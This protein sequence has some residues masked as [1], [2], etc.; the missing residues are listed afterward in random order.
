MLPKELKK[1][2]KQQ[3][4]SE[5]KFIEKNCVLHLNFFPAQGAT[6]KLVVPSVFLPKA[7]A[8]KIALASDDPKEC[9]NQ[10]REIVSEVAETCYENANAGIDKFDATGLI[11]L[12]EELSKFVYQSPADGEKEVADDLEI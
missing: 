6:G 11:L 1:V 4:L 5:K 2:F 7:T 10:I 9:M 3:K 12:Q 8:K